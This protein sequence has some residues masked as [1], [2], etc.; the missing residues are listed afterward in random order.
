MTPPGPRE[1]FDAFAII[2]GGVILAA[3]AAD[4]AY[5][6]TIIDD[7]QTPWAECWAPGE[8]ARLALIPGIGYEH[9]KPTP[10]RDPW[11][12]IDTRGHGLVVADGWAFPG[13]RVV[14][15]H[16]GSARPEKPSHIPPVPLPAI[17]G[18]LVAMAIGALLALWWRR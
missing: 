18:S 5:G 4:H 15:A 9:D 14:I 17:G 6:D 7:P 1:I 12:R 11:P 10:V 2:V 3:A 8:L 16:D 13:S